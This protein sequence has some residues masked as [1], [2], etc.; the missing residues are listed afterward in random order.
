MALFMPRVLSLNKFIFTLYLI[1]K[2]ALYFINCKTVAPQWIS[3]DFYSGNILFVQLCTLDYL[4]LSVRKCLNDFFHPSN[5][6]FFTYFG[7]HFFWHLSRRYAVNEFDTRLLIRKSW[8]W[9]SNIIVILIFCSSNSDC[10]PFL[11]T[12]VWADLIQNYSKFHVN[13]RSFESQTHYI[14][15]ELFV[16]Q[17]LQT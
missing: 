11:A 10:L 14:T 5:F 1:C 12:L 15:T 4:F 9:R 8:S 16:S 17:T 6:E 13:I 3:R 7:A 2:P